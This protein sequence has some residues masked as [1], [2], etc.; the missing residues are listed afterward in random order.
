VSATGLAAQPGIERGIAHA[1]VQALVELADGEIVRQADR[2]AAILEL[3]GR[4]RQRAPRG[5]MCC[6]IQLSKPR[7]EQG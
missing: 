7:S 6:A 3:D 4:A 5:R 2:D 1:V